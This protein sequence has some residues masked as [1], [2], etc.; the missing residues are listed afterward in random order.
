MIA[1]PGTASNTL[2]CFRRSPNVIVDFGAT[3]PRVR[4]LCDEILL[5]N[6]CHQ[7]AALKEV[8]T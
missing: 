1:K 7:I 6:E 2:Y 8:L 3:P 4:V 5:S